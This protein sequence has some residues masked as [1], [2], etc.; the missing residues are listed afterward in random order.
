MIKSC[1]FAGHSMVFDSAGIFLKLLTEIEKLITQDGVTE[2]R[3]GNYGDF[4]RL[5][6]R[7]VR[8]LKKTY[9]SVRL[10]LTIPYITSE[11]ANNSEYFYSNFDEITITGF[12]ENTPYKARIIMCNRQ[13]VEHSQFLICHVTHTWGG[14][15]KTLEYAKINN[16]KI[17][18]I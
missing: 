5:S 2:F 14:A 10:I 11:I 15:A 7:A 3:V 8:E 12:S 16:L 13:S 9:P 4:D 6:A 17:I 1:Y 18:N